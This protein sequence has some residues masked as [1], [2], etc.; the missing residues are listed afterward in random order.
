MEAF[1]TGKID[2]PANVKGFSANEGEGPDQYNENIDLVSDNNSEDKGIFTNERQLLSASNINELE[3][4]KNLVE[5][6][7]E[8]NNTKLLSLTK[9]GPFVPKTSKIET[10]EEQLIREKREKVATELSAQTSKLVIF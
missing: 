9:N 3:I 1:K 8:H 4:N 2:D 5:D 10:L 7:L 6:G